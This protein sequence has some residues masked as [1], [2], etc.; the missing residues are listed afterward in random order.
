MSISVVRGL[1]VLLLCSM[2]AACTTIGEKEEL[3]ESGYSSEPLPLLFEGNNIC[4]YYDDELLYLIY[5]ER[6]G[7]DIVVYDKKYGIFTESEFEESKR[8]INRSKR[9]SDFKCS[10]YS[11]RLSDK[12]RPNLHYSN[13]IRYFILS[14]SVRAIFD[15]ASKNPEIFKSEIKYNSPP[16][17][18]QVSDYYTEATVQVGYTGRSNRHSYLGDIKSYYNNLSPS[19]A[20]ELINPVLAKIAEE[21]AEK[22]RKEREE[23]LRI[24]L[25]KL[26]Q[27]IAQERWDNRLGAKYSIGDKVCT[28]DT[29]SFGYIEDLNINKMKVHVVG[30]ADRKNGFFFSGIDGNFNYKK[31]EAIRWFD[32]N[33]LAHCNFN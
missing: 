29:N 4:G 9:K 12:L 10:D 17:F 2:S 6:L 30:Q 1:V 5:P 15:N 19:D 18:R 31:V 24:E 25:F 32:R 3:N 23:K 7:S 22:E 16:Y 20:D 27:R 21:Q 26:E 33:E 13:S 8:I 14:N 11:I 28:Y